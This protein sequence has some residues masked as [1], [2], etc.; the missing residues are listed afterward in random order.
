MLLNERSLLG[1]SDI[2]GCSE[3]HVSCRN[4]LDRHLEHLIFYGANLNSRT[5]AGNTPLHICA[6]G[7]QENCARILLFRGADPNL[8]NHGNQTP[9]DIAILSGNSELVALFSDFDLSQVTPFS[10]KPV[11]SRRRRAPG[12]RPNS[13]SP[14]P[15]ILV[16]RPNPEHGEIPRS[17]TVAN[18]SDLD[19]AR[20]NKEEML[21]RTMRKTHNNNMTLETESDKKR[22]DSEESGSECS[23]SDDDTTNKEMRISRRTFST[24]AMGKKAP[25]PIKAGL[26]T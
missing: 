12:S 18:K 10:E 20:G 25:A 13:S 17:V 23:D 22:P 24:G 15:K 8:V 16:H 2:K 19:I 5:D 26:G 21:L 11:Y 3:I 7:N 14:S 9:H 1:S 4:G 6:I